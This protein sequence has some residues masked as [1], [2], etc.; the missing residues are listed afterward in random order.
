MPSN[1]LC[2]NWLDVWLKYVYE[3]ESN[4]QYKL[5]TGISVLSTVVRKNVWMELPGSN[6]FL[7]QL[8]VLVGPSGNRKTSVA[9]VGAKILKATDTIQIIRD[10]ITCPALLDKMASMTYPNGNGQHKPQSQ[11]FVYADELTTFL[12]KATLK[13]GQT[14]QFL[15]SLFECPDEA[16]HI[17]KHSASAYLKDVYISMLS[18]TTPVGIDSTFTELSWRGGLGARALLVYGGQFIKNPD[19][20]P[21]DTRIEDNLIHD[22]RHINSLSGQMQFTPKAFDEYKDWYLKLEQL[23]EDTAI[24]G[25]LNRG[26]M[27]VRKLACILSLSES[28]TLYVTRDHFRAARQLFDQLCDD[29]ESINTETS[30][31]A[32][33]KNLCRLYHVIKREQI[34]T[35]TAVARVSSKFC[36]SPELEELLLQLQDMA[37]I[38]IIPP[39]TMQSDGTLSSNTLYKFLS[40]IPALE[41]KQ[42]PQFKVP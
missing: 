18:C 35:R 28:D 37:A 1:R 40:K 14:S 26:A 3:I 2:R 38:R 39:N 23:E 41:R 34:M 16:E 36:K 25:M 11:V 31:A 22:L 12:T 17:V 7:N 24:A 9:K 10:S 5:F 4:P 42:R 8:I 15:C 21:L 30:N 33:W 19:P 32:H 20:I 27:L 6:L 29:L 13:D